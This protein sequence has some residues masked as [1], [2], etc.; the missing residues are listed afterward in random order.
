MIINCYIELLIL[1]VTLN[2]SLS[3]KNTFNTS[4]LLT[5]CVLQEN[6][7]L[8]LDLLD[9]QSF[10]NVISSYVIQEF[11]LVVACVYILNLKIIAYLESSFLC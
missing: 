11:C 3:F 8:V 1:L 6:S 2:Q 5:N 7:L 4:P 9:P 10:F